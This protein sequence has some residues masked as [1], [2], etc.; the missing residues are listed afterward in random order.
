M[1]KFLRN[2]HAKRLI[3]ISLA[4]LI[5]PAF[6]L[7]GIDS[8]SG[9]PKTAGTLDG[10]KISTHAFIKHHDSLAREFELFYGINPRMLYGGFDMEE[11]VW[12]RIL[13]LNEAKRRGIKVSDEEVADFIARQEAFQKD[14]KFDSALYK[15]TVQRN[16]QLELRTFEE[17]VRQALLMTRMRDV[18]A[19]DAK[20]SEEEVRTE[21]NKRF[22]P[23]SIR[24]VVVSDA[25]V[26]EAAEITEEEISAEYEEIKDFLFFPQSVQVRYVTLPAD[27]DTAVQDTDALWTDSAIRTPYFSKQDPIPDVGIAPEM[28]REIFILVEAGDRTGWLEHEDKQYRFELVEKRS[29]EKM[30]RDE[31]TLIVRD[32]IRKQKAA[33]AV[34][35]KAKALKEATASATLTEAATAQGVEIYTLEK[36]TGEEYLEKIGPWPHAFAAIVEL[37]AGEISEPVRTSDGYAIFEVV[38]VGVPDDATWEKEREAF[39][40]EIN[41]RHKM[42][43]FRNEL[44]LLRVRLNVNPEAMRALFPSKHQQPTSEEEAAPLASTTAT[45]AS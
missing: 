33:Q 8:D 39:E 22:G 5:L 12:E 20:A 10:R 23:R 6:V 30:S 1:I 14:G 17:D 3:L 19:G 26:E 31:A 34:A 35:D 13:L 41:H 16:L 18:M 15:E 24:Y 44:E 11:A 4:I 36:Y 28:I 43:A 2:Q 21:F 27:A 25:S 38:S 45:P 40:K 9:F 42:E 29:Q 7:F 37:K 32:R